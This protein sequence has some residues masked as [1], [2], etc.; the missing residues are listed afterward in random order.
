MCRM[1]AES[2]SNSERTTRGWD[3]C[4]RGTGD[5]GAWTA[6]GA[7]HP[8][9]RAFWSDLFQAAGTDPARTMVDIAS[10]NG[11]VVE[12]ALNVSA[13]AP[14]DII[15]VD[16]S[17]AA[18]ANICRRFPGVQGLVCDARSIPLQARA[19]DLVTSQFGVEYAGLEAVDEAVRLLAP[20]GRL[21]LLIHHRAGSIYREC[22]ASLDAISR[23]QEC[24]FVPLAD[25]MLRAGFAAVRG[26]DRA[27][28]EAAASRLAPAVAEL[29]RIIEHHGEH[30]AGDTVARLYTDVGRIHEQLPNFDPGEV[31]DWLARM[32]TEL[33]DYAARMSAMTGSA[34]DQPA[35][36]RLA[37]GLRERLTLERSGPLLA[38]GHEL[39]LAWVLQARS[40]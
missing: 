13:S 9:I 33:D 31:L 2:R 37:A 23:V 12:C 11:A 22:T 16:I 39:P 3:S 4:W 14:P 19:F 29:E 36:A 10:G 24:R 20:G 26:A 8:A 35:F 27:P 21:A 7:G 1:I 28:Y 5:I 34:V 15:C 6:G 17:S 40:Q 32:E 25:E 18:I 38:P 30:V